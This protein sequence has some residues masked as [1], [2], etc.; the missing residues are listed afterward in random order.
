MTSLTEEDEAKLK[1]LRDLVSR[2]QELRANSVATLKGDAEPNQ[3][4]ADPN[5]VMVE[6]IL[7][8]PCLIPYE[9]TQRPHLSWRKMA[10]GSAGAA[11][12]VVCLC[13]AVVLSLVHTP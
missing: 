4:G 12:V 3:D 6:P 8:S 9:L 11:V 10:A 2:V 1:Y 7:P 5:F 13:T